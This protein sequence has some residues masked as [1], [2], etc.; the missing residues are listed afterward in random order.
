MDRSTDGYGNGTYKITVLE[1][2]YYYERH[3]HGS[4]WFITHFYYVQ[5]RSNFTVIKMTQPSQPPTVMPGRGPR[6]GLGGGGG[7]TIIPPPPLKAA[8][9]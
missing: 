8:G 4:G 2:K 7:P 6:V 9:V 1:A 5:F 3:T